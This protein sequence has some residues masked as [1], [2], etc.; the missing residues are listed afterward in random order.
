MLLAPNQG[1]PTKG[2][3]RWC[4][5]GHTCGTTK[6]HVPLGSDFPPGRGA[7]HA[8]AS[9]ISG[10][11]EYTKLRPT[12][13]SSRNDWS[14][15]PLGRRLGCP[16]TVGRFSPGGCSSMGVEGDSLASCAGLLPRSLR[17]W[18]GAQPAPEDVCT[19][20]GVASRCLILGQGGGKRSRLTRSMQAR[21]ALVR[22]FADASGLLAD[23]PVL[24]RLCHAPVASYHSLA[25]L[26]CS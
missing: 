19:N 7:C 18:W 25:P 6:A 8:C 24:S 15:W 3:L 16:G 1:V 22:E 26:K 5:R 23:V 9:P 2:A 17:A 21:A 12:S 13:H 14:L 20:S 11:P 10:L 4:R